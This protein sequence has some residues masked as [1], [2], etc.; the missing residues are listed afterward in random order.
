MKRTP[1]KKRASKKR[2]WHNKTALD[3]CRE[4][5]CFL[6][7]PGVCCGDSRTVVP[8]HANWS[9]YGKAGARK[10]DDI[11]TVPGCGVCH[12]WLDFGKSSYEEKKAAWER[13]YARWSTYRDSACDSARI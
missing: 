4:Q 3:A 10:A 11:Y 1:F 2:A 5:A 6:S 7:I 8:C 13:A 9:E 12:Y